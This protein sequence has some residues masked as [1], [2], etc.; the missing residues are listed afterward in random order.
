MCDV[1]IDGVDVFCIDVTFSELGVYIIWDETQH[2]RVGYVRFYERLQISGRIHKDL[3]KEQVY[4][5]FSKLGDKDVE[6]L[7]LLAGRLQ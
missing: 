3:I 7:P 5:M 6:S 4:G 2:I 1:L